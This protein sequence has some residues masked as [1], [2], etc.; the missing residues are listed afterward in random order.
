MID[1]RGFSGRLLTPEQNGYDDARKVWNGVID[2][3]PAVIAMCESAEQV[4]V[5][6]REARRLGLEIA[7]RGGGHNYAGHAVCDA[8]MMIHLGGMHG[9]EVDAKARRARVGGGAT[10][11]EL[12]A[13]TQEHG[14][15]APGGF[16]S[17]TGVGGLTLG[18]G[19]G[20]LTKL[21]GLSADNLVGA[22]VVTA[23]SQIVRASERE[24]ADLLWAL[25]GG[26]GNFGVVTTFEF[27]LHPVGPMIHM[28]MLF[29]GIE[30]GTD[31]LRLARETIP[32]LPDDATGFVAMGMNAPPAPFVPEEHRGKLGHALLIIGFGAPESHA[33][34]VDRIA[35]KLPP[36]FRFV[37][38]MPYTALQK[39]FD[40][41]AFWG[42]HAY[43]KSLFVDELSDGVLEVV[44]AHVPKKSSPLSFCPTFSLDGAFRRASD[45]ASA[46]GGSRSRRYLI[47][48]SCAA[49]VPELYAPDRAWVRGFIDAHKPHARTGAGYV[50]F[51][52]DENDDERVRATY[53]AKYTRL[54][55]LTARFDPA[56]VFHKNANIKPRA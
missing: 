8:G 7:V 41:S 9:I 1:I 13:A 29:W 32:S 18:G 21:A 45:D 12:D 28:A 3:R 33:A 39:M 5:A 44:A 22:E 31:A 53:G 26:G 54:A 11:A 25:R 43:E 36:L 17:H 6:V 47:N 51:I 37:T 23:D 10:W 19:I 30:S 35:S 34:I 48:L 49:P 27:A 20:W 38:P 46:F 42:Q 14:L 4:A 2:R 52:S 16:I 50:N 40:E 15:A 55:E 56:N 24:N